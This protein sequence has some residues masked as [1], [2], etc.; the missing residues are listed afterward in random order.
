MAGHYVRDVAR[1]PLRIVAQHELREHFFE[2]RTRHELS[3]AAH[4]IVGDDAA[5]VQDDHAVTELLDQFENVRAVEHRLAA[6]GERANQ[7]TKH[8]R[9]RHVEP[10]V[11]LVEDQ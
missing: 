11:G 2:R 1:G 5:A 6:R 10:R 3:K 7:M 8:Q 4:R 9:R